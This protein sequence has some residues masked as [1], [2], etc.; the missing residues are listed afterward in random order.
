[1]RDARWQATVVEEAPD[2]CAYRVAFADDYPVVGCLLELYVEQHQFVSYLL[3]E[4]TVPEG[5]VSAATEF[6]ARAN[7]GMKIGN[8]EID[9]NA[10]AVRYKSSVCYA[11]LELS[12]VLV[13][14]TVMMAL[15][16][17]QPYSGAYLAVVQEGKT[18]QEAVA[19]VDG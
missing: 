4:P 19:E 10:G 15:N 14:D 9:L 6:V 8:F 5:R 13:Y 18:P 1:M 17:A 12:K 16:S 3:L 2:F 7:F 11:G